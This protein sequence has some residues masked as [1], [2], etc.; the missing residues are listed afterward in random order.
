M[1]ARGWVP[2]TEDVPTHDPTPFFVCMLSSSSQPPPITSLFPAAEIP[3][4]PRRPTSH[5]RNFGAG[6]L[7][8]A[9][10]ILHISRRPFPGATGAHTP[11]SVVGR[12]SRD[13]GAWEAFGWTPKSAH[14]RPV[15]R[16]HPG[17]DPSPTGGSRRS[18]GPR[19]RARAGSPSIPGSPSLP[20]SRL[21]ARKCPGSTYPAEPARRK[22]MI[23]TYRSPFSP[24]GFSGL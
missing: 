14:L 23:G 16:T 22:K 13:S 2:A 3:G 7:H 10:S 5:R 18:L 4:P 15:P 9:L 17:T 1:H 12:A 6:S 21:S 20:G 11:A 24:G 19:P 8:S